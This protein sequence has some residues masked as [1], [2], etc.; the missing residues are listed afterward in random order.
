MKKNKRK[1][2]KKIQP[3]YIEKSEIIYKIKFEKKCKTTH[4]K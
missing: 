2:E 4:I 1:I 3:K